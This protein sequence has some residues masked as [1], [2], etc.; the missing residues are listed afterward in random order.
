MWATCHNCRCE[1][2]PGMLTAGR[3]PACHH[4]WM[5]HGQERPTGL[6]CEHCGVVTDTLVHDRCRTCYSYWHRYGQERPLS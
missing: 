6:V 1:R 4:Y 2:V 5:E 3:C